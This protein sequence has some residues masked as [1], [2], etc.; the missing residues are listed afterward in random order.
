LKELDRDKKLKSKTGSVFVKDKGLT[1]E[2]SQSRG[3]YE[4]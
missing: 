2:V 3:N 4:K 1:R